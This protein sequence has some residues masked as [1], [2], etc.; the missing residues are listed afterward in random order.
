MFWV[1]MAFNIPEN[2]SVH[3]PC[4]IPVCVALAIS[5]S[6]TQINGFV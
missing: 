1:F 6:Q 5:T 4:H 3:H 2:F